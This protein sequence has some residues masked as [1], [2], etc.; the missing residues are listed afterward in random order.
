MREIKF[1]YLWENI[2]EDGRSIVKQIW[3]LE[4]IEKNELI[5]DKNILIAK[6]QYT[7]LKDKDDVDIYEG[8]IVRADR[9]GNSNGD[10]CLYV[11]EYDNTNCCFY[12]NPRKVKQ[13]FG[14]SFDAIHCQ[15]IS[16]IRQ[17]IKVIGSI[18]ENPE[19]LNKI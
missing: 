16:E 14:R 2:I 3:T 6:R 4:E 10:N 18:Y 11:I 9:R 1:E 13:D 19:L 12:G 17:N 8:D 5:Y 7:G 15:P